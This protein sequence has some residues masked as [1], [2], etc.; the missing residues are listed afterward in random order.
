MATTRKQKKARKYTGSEMLSDIEN[1]DFVL[2]ANH[3]EREESEYSNSI[4]RS[5]SPSY[6]APENNEENSYPNSGEKRSS[7]SANYGHNSAG[8]DSSAEFNSLSVERNL[9]ISRGMDEM[10]NSVSVQIQR[11][12]NDA[13]SNQVLP[14][15]Q[16]A[17]RASSGPM[18]QKEW[19]V[20]AERSER[21]S[22]DNSNPKIRSSS[23]EPFRSRLHDEDADN[24]HH[25]SSFYYQNLF[26]DDRKW[27]LRTF[28]GFSKK[29]KSFS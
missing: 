5:G 25:S 22:E 24:A 10:M 26:P 18:T 1:P 27:K 9:R 13:M 12:I 23:G 15:I 6:I 7:N 8:T 11:A 16:N 21:N 29:T 20:S 4:R 2:G 3:L 14:Q 17:L 19:N 28:S